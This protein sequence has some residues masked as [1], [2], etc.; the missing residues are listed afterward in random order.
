[1]IM[2]L[3]EIILP[4]VKYNKMINNIYIFLILS[5]CPINDS[6]LRG[7]GRVSLDHNHQLMSN[8][9]KNVFL[10]VPNIIGIPY[11][12]CIHFIF[13]SLRLCKGGAGHSCLLLYPH[14]HPLHRS[15]RRLLSPGCGRW[16][17]RAPPPPKQQIRRRPRYGH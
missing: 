3:I 8:T 4:A 2:M 16:L 6:Q 1:M 5:A 11:T 17:C 9:H 7:R 15:L 13:Y 14:A 12:I 10:Y